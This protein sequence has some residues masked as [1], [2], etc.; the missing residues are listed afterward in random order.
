MEG[1]FPDKFL[2]DTF[3]DES[4]QNQNDFL[5]FTETETR[6][7]SFHVGSSSQNPIVED[8]LSAAAAAPP[9]APAAANKSDFLQYS[10]C[11]RAVFG[12][13]SSQNVLNSNE[14]AF[15]PYNDV[16]GT[17]SESGQ[18]NSRGINAKDRGHGASPAGNRSDFVQYRELP[19]TEYSQGSSDV[20][21]MRRRMIDYL[22][23]CPA[24][25]GNMAEYERERGFRHMINERMRRQ[26]QRQCCLALH[27]ILPFGTKNDV[28]SV[29]QMAAKEIQKLQACRDELKKQNAELEE[30]LNSEQGNRVELRLA[31]STSPIDSVLE[32]LQL[33]TDLGMNTR[34]IT[35]NFSHQEL[36]ALLEMHAN[37]M[38][39]AEVERG[40]ED[41]ENEN[42]WK[43][44]SH[45]REILKRQRL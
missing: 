11:L 5:Q 45:D 3:C 25:R 44:P 22:N 40:N 1:F 4:F 43:L 30:K 9:P 18:E 2:D 6:Q 42:E 28:N 33:L 13:E 20:M 35:S 31:H 27:S 37:K 41:A 24:E 21:N 34:S 38:G 14:V 8:E 12:Q 23:S 36:F 17:G 26:R 7:E 10:D 29:V 39:G 16:P 15:V 19:R 32:T